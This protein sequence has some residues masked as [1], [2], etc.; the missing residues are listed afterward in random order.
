MLLAVPALLWLGGCHLDMYDQPKYKPL[1]SNT[2]YDNGSASRPIPEGTVPHGDA[3]LDE[4]LY[5]GTVNGKPATIFPFPVT[6]S[7][8]QHGQNRFNTFCSPCHSRLGD[9]NGIIVQ[10]GFPRPKSFHEDSVR[11]EPVGFYFDVIT[12]GFGRMYSY[13][14]RVPVKD[15]WAIVAYIRALQLS[16]HVPVRMLSPHEQQ[17]LSRLKR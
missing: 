9:G 17:I 14:S 7:L 2:M 15:R 10:R 4:L 11:S 6:D 16:Q 3:N 13:A 5:K 12:H 1:S 8:L